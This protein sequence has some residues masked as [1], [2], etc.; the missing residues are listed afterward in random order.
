MAPRMARFN[1]AILGPSPYM[2]DLHR[3]LTEHLP[4]Y[5]PYKMHPTHLGDTLAGRQEQQ[6]SQARLQ[7]PI[8]FLTC[9]R[10]LADA[11]SVAQYTL[12]KRSPDG[13]HLCII[14]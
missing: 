6:Q 12:F 2:R 7:Q 3:K 1:H 5:S 4:W 13:W 8:P 9:L 11:K 10:Q 14:S